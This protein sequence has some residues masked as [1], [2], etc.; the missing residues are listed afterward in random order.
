MTK[1]VFNV[2]ESYEIDLDQGMITV[3]DGK[4]LAYF[5][6]E[7]EEYKLNDVA[8]KSKKQIVV[9]QCIEQV[10][11]YDSFVFISISE[12]MWRFVGQWSRFRILLAKYLRGLCQ[13][14]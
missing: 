4:D 7:K 14:V 13:Q 1:V 12:T 11:F 9:E 2:T 3:S 6:P 5:K 10:C 8:G